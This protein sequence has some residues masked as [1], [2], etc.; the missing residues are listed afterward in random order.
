MKLHVRIIRI[1]VLNVTDTVTIGVSLIQR[2]ILNAGEAAHQSSS[3]I[4]TSVWRR[5]GGP[6]APVGAGVLPAPQSSEYTRNAGGCAC[7]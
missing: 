5:A 3:S 4:G 7:A 6:V 2:I 1:G